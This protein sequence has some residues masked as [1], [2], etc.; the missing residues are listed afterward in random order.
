MVV[1]REVP[2]ETVREVPVYV[3]REVL[4]ESRVEVPVDVVR[5]VEKEV[6]V[7]LIR[8]VPVE[9]VRETSQALPDTHM[10]NFDTKTYLM[11]E[12]ERA[13]RAS[14]GGGFD[15]GGGGGG[16]GFDGG[17]GGLNVPPPLPPDMVLRRKG[18]WS[19]GPRD[20]G[21][22]QSVPRTDGG[23]S[24][25][26]KPLD[27]ANKKAVPDQLAATKSGFVSGRNVWGGTTE[28]REPAGQAAARAKAAIA[29]ARAA[30]GDS[31]LG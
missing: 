12:R 25:G 30:T 14:G 9:V 28:R 21:R 29:A 22:A 16:G 20:A 11:S 13:H 18:G 2:V 3:D 24:Q 23:A 31:R 6:A 15:G 10:D 27:P 7:E 17:G 5:L 4:V 26:R 1:I 19:D 8:E